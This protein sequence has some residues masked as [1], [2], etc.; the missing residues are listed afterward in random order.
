METQISI[1]RTQKKQTPTKEFCLFWSWFM[2]ATG[3]KGQKKQRFASSHEKE[4]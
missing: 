1:L 3:E 2:V 4:T